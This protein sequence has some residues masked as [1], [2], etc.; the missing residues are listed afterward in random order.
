MKNLIFFDTETTSKDNARLVQLAIAVNEE[1]IDVKTF[2][3]AEPITIEAMEIHGITNEM[4]EDKKSFSQEVG[5]CQS[6]FNSGIAVAHNA[7][8]DIEV[9]KREGVVIEQYIDTLRVAQHLLPDL[10]AHRLQYLRYALDLKPQEENLTAHDA[11]GDVAVLRGLFKYL[12]FCIMGEQGIVEEEKVLEKLFEMTNTPVTLLKL[13]FGKYKDRSFG[14]IQQIDR[15][16]LRWLSIQP[17]LSEDLAYT[18]NQY[19]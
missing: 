19:V 10:P 8:F 3:P 14:E 7:K 18:L 11:A 16:Y 1:R 9:M 4:V 6:V 13:P 12:V 2:K 17:D 5:I 15:G